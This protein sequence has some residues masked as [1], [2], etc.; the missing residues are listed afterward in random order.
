MTNWVN[1]NE[2]YKRLLHSKAVLPLLRQ[3]VI[4][5]IT[6][7]NQKKSLIERAAIISG[8]DPAVSV[9][10]MFV[11]NT[12]KKAKVRKK[13]IVFTKS[14]S[15]RLDAYL[16][17]MIAISAREIFFTV[18]LPR[19]IIFVDEVQFSSNILPT[20]VGLEVRQFYN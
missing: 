13:L 11:W 3:I 9:S 15:T 12:Y 17:I 14:K 2:N 16:Q 8:I 1:L 20:R 10:K 7:K 19:R 18:N 6:I 5:L 4:D